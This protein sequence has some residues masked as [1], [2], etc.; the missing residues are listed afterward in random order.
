MH[1]FKF[2]HFTKLPATFISMNVFF[3]FSNGM[4]IFPKK[5]AP[6]AGSSTYRDYNLTFSRFSVKTSG[7][8]LD[9]SPLVI[10]VTNGGGSFSLHLV[11]LRWVGQHFS[12][13][14]A[15]FYIGKKRCPAPLD[16]TTCQIKFF[17]IVLRDRKWSF[18]NTV[19]QNLYYE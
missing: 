14:N 17:T 9:V 15:Y 16:L 12:L 6:A 4:R 1:I 2:T 5:S 8:D 10:M 7:Q 13:C 11:K 3:F 19:T 18:T